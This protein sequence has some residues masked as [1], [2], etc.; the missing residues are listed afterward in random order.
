MAEGDPS[1]HWE[2]ERQDVK[3]VEARLS[4]RLQDLE[5]ARPY[6]MNSMIKEQRE[7]QR[8]Q[9]GNSRK[10]AHVTLGDLSQ[11]VGKKP[12]LPTLPTSS[13]QQHS[14]SQAEQ[15]RAPRSTLPKM[16]GPTRAAQSPLQHQTHNGDILDDAEQESSGRH[17]STSTCTQAKAASS[18]PDINLS[19][20]RYSIA[21]RLNI[22][23]NLAE[24]EE[25]S[26][27][28]ELGTGPTVLPHGQSEASDVDG[29]D[30]MPKPPAEASCTGRRKPSL[31][32]EKLSSDTDAYAP[33]SSHLRSMHSRPGFL[34]LYAEARKARFI[35]H[36]GIPA[37]G[38]ELSLQEIFGH[39]N[40]LDPS[41]PAEEQKQHNPK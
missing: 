1:R 33:D 13:G 20:L 9:Q 6:H 22:S 30:T 18:I 24:Q 23:A 11:E 38:K 8:L 2:L 25:T 26:S 12:A 7:I 36:K 27:Q 14:N 31:G 29:S 34:E 39:V 4:H 10:K 5:E 16:E 32:H 41:P 28:G 3:Q 15:L 19:D 37:S 35:R 21:R 40:S 17:G